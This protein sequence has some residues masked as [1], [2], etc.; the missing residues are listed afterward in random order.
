MKKKR[1][2]VQSKQIYDHQKSLE[3]FY[4]CPNLILEQKVR[5]RHIS[6]KHDDT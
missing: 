6:K 2:N 3:K 4:M 1:A 5:T